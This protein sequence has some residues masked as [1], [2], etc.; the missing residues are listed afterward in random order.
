M[1]F[2]VLDR[3]MKYTFCGGSSKIFKSAF[4]DS[5]RK[6]SIQH[7]IN[8]FFGELKEDSIDE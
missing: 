8:I 1:M 5:F 6:F 7:R 3:S 2:N 4:E